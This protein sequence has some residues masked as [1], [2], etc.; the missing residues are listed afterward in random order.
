MKNTH[1]LLMGFG[2]L[3]AGLFVGGCDE[4]DAASLRLKLNAGPNLGGSIAI[5]TL[6]S[7]AQS[8]GA[9]QMTSGKDLAWSGRA[10]VTLSRGTFGELAK[11]NVGELTFNAMNTPSQ[12][13]LEVTLPRGA[14]VKW[15]ALLA[16]GD[17]AE[18][19]RARLVLDPDDADSKLGKIV[20]IVIEA[21]AKVT[22]TDTSISARGLKASSD[23]KEATLIVPI[24]EATKDGEPIRWTIKWDTP[25]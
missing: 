7:P 4:S 21:P 8:P 11:L 12:T 13:I 22:G 15:P 18:R 10:S 17:D 23:Q 20:K 19:G 16:A 24:T 2:L 3:A 14:S 25:R 1:A 6:A 9:E 5:S